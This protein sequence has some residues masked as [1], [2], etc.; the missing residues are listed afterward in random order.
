MSDNGSDSLP[1]EVPEQENIRL[2]EENARLRRRLAVHS[3]PIPQAAPESPP[4][5]KPVETAPPVDKAER[6]P[7][8]ERRC[9]R[10]VAPPGGKLDSLARFLVPLILTTQELHEEAG[11]RRNPNVG[12]WV[13][14]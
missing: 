4:P 3:I 5:A 13:R 11:N 7:R 1:F 6:A 12:Q 9:T 8:K 10:K 2:T 14:R